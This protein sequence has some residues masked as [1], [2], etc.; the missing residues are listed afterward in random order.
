MTSSLRELINDPER[1]LVLPGVTNA[2]SAKIA[3]DVG[4]DALYLTGAG[5]T[6][7]ELALPDLGFISLVDVAAQVGRIRDVVDAPIVVD[8]DTGFGNALNVIQSVRV[9]ERNGANAIQIEDQIFPKRCGHFA[10]K[11]VTSLEEMTSKI[12]AAVDTR[13]SEDFL[14][15]A[16]TDALAV[17]NIEEV[18]RRTGAY[19][20]AGADIIFV[21]AL[22]TRE[23]MAKVPQ[24]VALPLLINMVEG[25]KTPLLEASE[26][27]V[28]G[29]KIILYANSAMRAAMLAMQH[30]LRVLKDSGSTTSVLNEIAS[31]DERQR[32]VSKPLY[33]EY[34]R[35]YSS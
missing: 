34:E 23:E 33:D 30:V 11:G 28:L 2:L 10:G 15:I 29:Y 7:T 26:L 4:F 14:V 3:V 5:V 8:S 27:E 16:R 9:L 25:G 21:E 24:H 32:L 20:E 35:R 12:K 6:N 17:A 31:W 18:F 1:A 19:G 22:T 13:K